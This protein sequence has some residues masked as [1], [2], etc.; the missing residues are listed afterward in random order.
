MRKVIK[1][2]KREYRNYMENNL[3]EID[4]KLA[5]AEGM[6]VFNKIPK[7]KKLRRHFIDLSKRKA[8]CPFPISHKDIRRLEKPSKCEVPV[9]IVDILELLVDDINI[10][11]DS[12]T[13][14]ARPYDKSIVSVHIL[15]CTIEQITMFRSWLKDHLDDQNYANNKY[16]D[17]INY[18]AGRLKKFDAEYPGVF[19]T[20]FEERG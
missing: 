17:E 5:I 1:L 4:D 3:S 6:A 2:S 18:V 10:Y 8:D 12:F 7:R 16:R 20:L 13:Y 15:R 19:N 14:R 9:N 11:R